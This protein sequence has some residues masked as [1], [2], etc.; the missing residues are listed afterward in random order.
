MRLAGVSDANL[1]EGWVE[2]RKEREADVALLLEAAIFSI[3]VP[4]YP[5]PAALPCAALT[6]DEE[7]KS[8]G[9]SGLW[10]KSQSDASCSL[11]HKL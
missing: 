4:H 9:C 7:G 5:A 3:P 2:Q 10:H 6:H 8:S 1:Q 11:K